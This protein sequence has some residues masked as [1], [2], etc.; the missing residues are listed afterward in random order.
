MITSTLFIGILLSTLASGWHCALMCGS[1]SMSIERMDSKLTFYAKKQ[2]FVRQQLLMHFGRIL[3]Y[4]LLGGLASVVGISVWRQDI[5]QIQRYL[6]ALAGVIL[7][8]QAYVLLGRERLA[9]T[10]KRPRIGQLL[11][12]NIATAWAKRFYELNQGQSKFL[13]G[14]LWGLVPC[15]LVYSV[16]LLA[17]LSGDLISGMLMM[18]ALGLGTLPNLFILSKASAIFLQ[19]GRQPWVRNTAGGLMLGSSLLIFYRSWT[20]PQLVLREG[21]CFI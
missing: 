10:F 15:G 11:G 9:P 14:M 2:S 20:L 4:I 13:T 21:F 3:S 17:F 6:Y 1:I 16:L 12:Q 5:L 19:M 7:L 8:Y 18:F